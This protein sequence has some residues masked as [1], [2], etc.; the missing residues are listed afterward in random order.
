MSAEAFVDIRELNL[1]GATHMLSMDSVFKDVS[2]D[3]ASQ[4]KVSQADIYAHPPQLAHLAQATRSD[5]KVD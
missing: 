3:V 5:R 1:Q 4:K 2:F